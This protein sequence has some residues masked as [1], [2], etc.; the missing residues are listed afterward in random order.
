MTQRL[1]TTEDGFEVLTGWDRPLQYFFLDISRQCPT[2]H[3][4]NDSD[5]TDCN[6]CDATGEQRIFGNL[7]S[8]KYP[9]GAMT[10]DEV[11]QEIERHLTAW[12]DSLVGTLAL[13]KLE[14]RGNDTQVYGIVGQVKNHE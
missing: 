14:N 2:C 10:L 5:D 12:P 1:W 6:A 9:Y 11:M 3:G 8:P 7:D 13:D 4:Q